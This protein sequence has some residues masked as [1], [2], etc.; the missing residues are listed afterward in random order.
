MAKRSASGGADAQLARLKA[1]ES[2]PTA[3]ESIDELT[4][5]LRG[6]S[7]IVA[8]RAAEI[9][10]TGK[11]TAL[12]PALVES[13]RSFLDHEDKGCLAKAAIAKALLALGSR[14]EEVLLAGATHVQ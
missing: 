6:K 14:E 8:A 12:E 9:V 11:L 7:N 2:D 4:S 13:F 10:A 5:A 1:I 3:P